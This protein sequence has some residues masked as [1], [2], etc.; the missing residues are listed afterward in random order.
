MTATAVIERGQVTRYAAVAACTHACG[1]CAAIFKDKGMFHPPRPSSQCPVDLM[2]WA[3]TPIA[4][5]LSLMANPALPLPSTAVGHFLGCPPPA[6]A[7]QMDPVRLVDPSNS[8]LQDW[9]SPMHR[10]D[11][12]W[13]ED[14]RC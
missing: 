1:A 4:I 5:R 6:F 13:D 12:H 3:T 10:N 11:L 7:A 2:E 14:L 8:G 9:T